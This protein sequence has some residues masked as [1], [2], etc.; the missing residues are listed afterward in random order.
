MELHF[1]ATQE[2]PLMFGCHY[3]ITDADITLANDLAEILQ[4]FYE[5]NLQVLIKG[6]ARLADVVVFIDQITSHLSSAISDE[7]HAYP[8]A[9]RNACRGGLQLTNKYYTLTD[10]SPLYRVAMDQYFK[11]A[12][13]DQ[14]WIDEAIWLTHEM[15]ETNYKPSA[16][17]PPSKEANPRPKPQ[18]G[19]LAQLSGASEACA[20]NNLTDPLNMWLAGGL[21]LNKEGLPVCEISLMAS[22]HTLGDGREE[23]TSL[24]G[25]NQDTAMTTSDP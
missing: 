4:P 13:W 14:E 11:L 18:T 23:E 2:Y 7:Q 8:P 1:V 17:P 12:K 19:V 16:Q 3:H 6:S 21:H 24:P 15:W 20:G 9:L 10:C 5:I 25:L 22:P